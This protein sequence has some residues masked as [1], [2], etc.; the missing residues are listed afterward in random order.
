M[1]SYL[2][3]FFVG[4]GKKFSTKRFLLS[5]SV[6]SLRDPVTYLNLK[7]SF[8]VVVCRLRK[9]VALLT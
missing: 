9:L 5:Y 4:G 7:I 1:C 8:P 6:L 2:L 3:P